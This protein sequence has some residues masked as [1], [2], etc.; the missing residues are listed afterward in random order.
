[1]FSCIHYNWN[2]PSQTHILKSEF[3]REPPAS[4]VFQNIV[5]NPNTYENLNISIPAGKMSR[6]K[7][8]ATILIMNY[9][10]YFTNMNEWKICHFWET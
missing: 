4:M 9:K 1:M 6:T 3:S 5:Q 10:C 2:P 8:N 7:T